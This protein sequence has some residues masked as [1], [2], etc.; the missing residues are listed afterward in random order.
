MRDLVSESSLDPVHSRCI[1]C[2]SL[3]L[4]GVRSIVQKVPLVALRVCLDCRAQS[5]NRLPARGYLD[6]LYSAEEYAG[7]LESS[8]RLTRAL[9]GRLAAEFLAVSPC[10]TTL[11]ILDYGGGSGALGLAVAEKLADR[12]LDSRVT[13]VD[14]SNEGVLEGVKFFTPESFDRDSENFDVIL[15]SAVVEH[16]RDPGIRLQALFERLNVRGWMYVRS[17]QLAGLAR[18]RP[19]WYRWPRHLSDFGPQFWSRFPT[20]AGWEVDTVWSRACRPETEWRSRPL[21]T[22]ASTLLKSPCSAEQAVR[23]VLRLSRS[24][25]YPFVG[26]WEFLGRKHGA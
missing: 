4:S 20:L 3:N 5:V 2:G 6:S 14:L 25:R 13:V 21:P 12:D 8:K 23:R 15:C 17:P 11:R 10:P 9:G 22:A 26:G 16:L 18:L 1:F 7:H 24:C 19:S